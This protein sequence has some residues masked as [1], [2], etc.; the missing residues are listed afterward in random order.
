MN[1]SNHEKETFEMSIRRLEQIVNELERGDLALEESL[2]RYEEGIGRLRRCHVM[3]EETKKKVVLLTKNCDGSLN[4]VNFN[5]KGN[6]G[7]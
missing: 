7:A 6:Q 5:D 3:L 2:A 1:D 4:E